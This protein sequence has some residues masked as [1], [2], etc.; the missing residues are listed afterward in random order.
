MTLQ[1]R[2]KG[3]KTHRAAMKDYN[4]LTPAEVDTV[5]DVIIE[6]GNRGRPPSHRRLKEHVDVSEF[7]LAQTFQ[8]EVLGRIGRIVLQSSMLIISRLVQPVPWRRNV[9]C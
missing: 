3:R 2:A 9:Q 1:C 7:V 4:W 8:R 5:I 6:L